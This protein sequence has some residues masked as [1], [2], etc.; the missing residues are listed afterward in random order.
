MIQR[1]FKKISKR[2]GIKIDPALEIPDNWAN[3]GVIVAETPVIATETPVIATETPVSVT[4]TPEN[5][6]GNGNQNVNYNIFLI[7]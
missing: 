5:G 6:N 2:I 7:E 3:E 4:K 1:C